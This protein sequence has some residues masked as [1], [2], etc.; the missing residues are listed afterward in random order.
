MQQIGSHRS[1]QGL[2]FDYFLYPV[3]LGAEWIMIQGIWVLLTFHAG[4]L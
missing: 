2:S 4:P 3:L 1:Q